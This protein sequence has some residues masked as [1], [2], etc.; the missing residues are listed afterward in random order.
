MPLVGR[1]SY[2]GNAGLRTMR[3]AGE[4]VGFNLTGHVYSSPLT[5]GLS[6]M[7]NESPPRQEGREEGALGA[8][9]SSGLLPGPPARLLCSACVQQPPT[10]QTQGRDFS[11]N[12]QSDRCKASKNAQL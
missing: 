11:R 3:T 6:E 10:L 1:L 8:S 5:F 2:L 12:K 7:C 4:E 9:P